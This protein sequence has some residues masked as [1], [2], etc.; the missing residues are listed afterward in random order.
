MSNNHP[1]A[2]FPIQCVSRKNKLGNTFF[3]FH[4]EESPKDWDFRVYPTQSPSEAELGRFFLL[5]LRK[6][7]TQEWRIIYIGN[8]DNEE[9]RG[10]GI[11]NALLPAVAHRYGI[12]ICSSTRKGDGPSEVMETAK[13]LRAKHGVFFSV[14]AS[15][16]NSRNE[17]ATCMWGRIRRHLKQNP[18]EFRVDYSKSEDVFRLVKASASPKEAKC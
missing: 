4:D 6:L 7:E 10:K 2:P 11:P 3:V 5:R 9:F 18:G 14:D 8:Q 17:F 13:T 15:G 12:Q 16:E 1:R